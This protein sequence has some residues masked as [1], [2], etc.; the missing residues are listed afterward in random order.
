MSSSGSV[1][2]WLMQLK[3]GDMAAL[4]RLHQRYW[5]VL[6]DLA[7]RKLQGVPC[8]AADEEDAA[9]EAFLGFCSSLRA[10]HLPALQD[11]HGFLALL[12]HIIAC[13]THN[14]IKHETRSKRPHPSRQ[15][16]A[17]VLATLAEETELSPYQLALLNDCYEHFVLG[18]ADNLRQYAVLHLA[19]Y[20]NADIARQTN[21]SQQTVGRKLDLIRT[22]WRRMAAESVSEEEKS[23]SLEDSTSDC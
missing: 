13:K 9:Q 23:G 19:G 10:G 7:R 1:T 17:S 5:P 22:K 4:T 2:T 14:Q 15:A 6:V 11:R 21:R 8:R 20:S 12:T 18:L 3:A 16:D